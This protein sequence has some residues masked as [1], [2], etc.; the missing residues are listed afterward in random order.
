MLFCIEYLLLK[1]CLDCLRQLHCFV[2]HGA[3]FLAL[4]VLKLRKLHYLLLDARI[5]LRKL[6]YPQLKGVNYDLH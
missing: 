6:V 5:Y 2:H 3:H 4:P 1:A